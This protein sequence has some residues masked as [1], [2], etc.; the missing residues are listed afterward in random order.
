MT[1][2]INR[3]ARALHHAHDRRV[4]ARQPMFT[5]SQWEDLDPKLQ[6]EFDTLAITI[7]RTRNLPMP[8]RIDRLCDYY[9]EDPGSPIVRQYFTNRIN[10]CQ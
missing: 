8:V 10:E 7:H 3:M 4:Q 1:S 5:P 9:D 2:E 6:D